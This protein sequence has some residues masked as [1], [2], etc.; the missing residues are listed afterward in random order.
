MLL[1][2]LAGSLLG[3][4]LVGK[5]VIRGC[6]GVNGAGEEVFKAGERQDF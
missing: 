6:N 2:T 5:V 3:N 4:T 1:G